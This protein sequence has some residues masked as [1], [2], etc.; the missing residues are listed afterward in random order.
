MTTTI[1][2]ISSGFHDAAVSLINTDGE[3][4]FAGHAE[5]YSKVKHDRYI[6]DELISEALKHTSIGSLLEVVYYE[7]IYKK[8]AR[9]LYSVCASN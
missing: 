3:V 9:Q 2:G 5:R 4:L 8:K 7:N 6:N 1:L